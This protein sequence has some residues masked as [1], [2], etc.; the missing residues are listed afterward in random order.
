MEI[1]YFKA[2]INLKQILLFFIKRLKH[3]R[4]IIKNFSFSNILSNVVNSLIYVKQKIFITVVLLFLIQ[5]KCI[6]LKLLISQSK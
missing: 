3:H 4:Q 6:L 5:F 2:K 1:K